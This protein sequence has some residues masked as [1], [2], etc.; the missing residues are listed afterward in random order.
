M[1]AD[2]SVIGFDDMQLA[3]HMNPPLTT[4]R[5]DKQG[6]GRAVGAALVAM[7]ESDEASDASSVTLPVELVVRG[8][9]APPAA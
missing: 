8:S 3:D 1:P 4:L 2:I 7:I 9:S 5:Q 6:L